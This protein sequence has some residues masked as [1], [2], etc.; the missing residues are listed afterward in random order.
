MTQLRIQS[1]LKCFLVSVL[2]ALSIGWIALVNQPTQAQDFDRSA[3]LESLISDT[4]LPLHQ[5]LLEEAMALETAGK[6]FDD[7][8]NNETLA[9]FQQAWRDTSTAYE[10][11]EVYRFR[12]VMFLMTQID[13]SPPNISI[14]E[15][16]IADSVPIDATLAA[17]LGSVL[18]GLPALEY[19]IFDED[20]LMQ[21]TESNTRRNYAVAL[22]GD[23]KRVATELLEEWTLEAGGYGDRFLS[24]DGEP[25]SVR[26][27]LS[28]L[29]NEM[30]AQLET[31]VQF[32]LGVP[33]GYDNRRVPQPASVEAPYSETSIE[34]V[35]ANL[36]GFG[37]AFNGVGD[38]DSLAGYLDFL[39]ATYDGQRMSELINEQLQV[40][41]DALNQ[42]EQPL[43]ITV[44]E[45]NET[46]T[47]AYNEANQLLRLFKTDVA[48]QLG[49]TVT[50]GDNDGD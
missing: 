26:S 13:S 2:M 6:A 9:A 19:L 49:I 8:P 34:K 32:R 11:V 14:I 7:N 3:M 33:L 4:I 38:G 40:T 47:N 50:F 48:S 28:M 29:S 27:S 41:V 35:I 23:I 25:N 44:I 36:E 43:S 15:T 20:A 16:Y 46:V 37:M 42:I 18:K 39:G 45:D 1:V 24:A 10:Q 12:R 21:L 30:I 17:S 22:T 5:T 31:I